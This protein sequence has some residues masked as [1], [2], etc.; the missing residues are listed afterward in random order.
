[1]V[2]KLFPMLGCGSWFTQT[3]WEQKSKQGTEQA[4][5]E[6]QDRAG[7]LQRLERI[8]KGA[9]YTGGSFKF[10]QTCLNSAKHPAS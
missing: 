7:S 9:T 3:L 1:M 5:L 10:G 4:L 2:R 6:M 8:I